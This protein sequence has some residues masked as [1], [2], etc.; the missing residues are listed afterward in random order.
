MRLIFIR[1]AEPDY[2]HNSLT[3]KG[4]REAKILSERV[5]KWKNIDAVYVSPLERAR[6]TA[7][8]SLEKLHMK[9]TTV[10]W[11]QEFVYMITDPTTG[12]YP[13]VPWDF[14]PEYWTKQEAFFDPDAFKD[15]EIMPDIYRTAVDRL[16]KGIDEILA[17]Y[18]YHRNGGYYL[19][20]EDKV[21]GDDEKTVLFFGHL[22]ANSEA[23]GYLIDVSPVLLQQTIYQAPTSVA[24]LNFEKRMPGTAAARLQVI[25]STMHLAAA[26]EPVSKMG[27]FS[28]V[29]QEKI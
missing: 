8:P 28:E 11:L 7:A 9:A 4:F 15:H 13:S 1:H 26:G 21:K 18:G 27:A 24:I 23:I 12:H 17:G 29:M 22:G 2:E 16:R 3:E 14:M 20:E 5:A 19:T 6:L 10:N 25:G